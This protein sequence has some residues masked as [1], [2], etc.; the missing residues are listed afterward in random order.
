MDTN[1]TGNCYMDVAFQALIYKYRIGDMLVAKVFSNDKMISASTEDPY[2]PAL[3]IL[4]NSSVNN[5]IKVDQYIPL[6]ISNVM[7]FPTRLAPVLDVQVFTPPPVIKYIVSS[8][9]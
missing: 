3:C 2:Y 1:T 5:I 9:I 7:I 6:I 8:K 4:K